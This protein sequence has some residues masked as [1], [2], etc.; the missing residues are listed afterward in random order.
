MLGK[1]TGS[2]LLMI[3]AVL[4]SCSQ[5]DR[6]DLRLVGYRLGC[7]FVEPDAQDEGRDLVLG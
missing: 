3:A 7:A 5:P 2:L 4:V 6:S 1:T